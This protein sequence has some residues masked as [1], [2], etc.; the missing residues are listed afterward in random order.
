MNDD[1]ELLELAAKAEGRRK[2]FEDAFRACAGVLDKHM[3]AYV[4]FCNAV[5]RIAAEIG[6]AKAGEAI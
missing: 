5:A 3:A 2:R 6:K 1:K 4:S